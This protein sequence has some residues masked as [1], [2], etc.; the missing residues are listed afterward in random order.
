MFLLGVIDTAVCNDQ[1]SN[2]KNQTVGGLTSRHDSFVVMDMMMTANNCLGQT[3]QAHALVLHLSVACSKCVGHI[4]P[5]FQLPAHGTILESPE[6]GELV[7][8]TL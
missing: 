4:V 5:R 1:V 2:P 6:F 3:L 7:V 8:A